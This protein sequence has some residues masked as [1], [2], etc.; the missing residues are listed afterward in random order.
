ME[1]NKETNRKLDKIIELLA[2]S[3]VRN[4]SN[5]MISD[6]ER[7]IKK[8]E[9]EGDE[10]SI[11][12]QTSFDRIHDK[13]FAI[14][15]ILIVLFVGLSKFPINN[16]IFQLWIFILP[17]LNIFYLVF[18]EKSQMEIFRHASQ[19]MNWNFSTDVEKYGR[20]INSQNLKS[21]LSILTTIGLTVFA[22]FK[23]ILY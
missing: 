5:E 3:E 15:S 19:R 4:Q 20:M 22:A 7:L 6:S 17:I 8:A 23:I 21:L 11:K 10:A 13:L 9:K 1:S 14:N 12:I 16:P 18:L 2:K